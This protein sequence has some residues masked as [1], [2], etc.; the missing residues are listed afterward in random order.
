MAASTR[1][2]V[3]AT[4]SH[5]QWGTWYCRP[6]TLCRRE[7]RLGVQR[8]RGRWL[9]GFL[10]AA[11]VLAVVAIP[12]AADTSL[13]A[14][15]KAVVSQTNGDG[16]NVRDAVG[17]GGQ[18]I[19]ALPEGSEVD[20][21]G[22]P[23]QASDG[24]TWYQVSAYGVRGWVISDYL[25]AGGGHA[26]YQGVLTVVG[27]NGNGL[28]LRDG[29]SSD[30]ATLTVLPEGTQVTVVGADVTD[31]A[32]NTWANISFNGTTGYSS[33]AYLSTGGAPATPA[34]QSAPAP[35]SGVS[36][37]GNAEVGGTNGDGLNLRSDATYGSSIVAVAPDGS[38]VH[39]I[40]GSKTDGDGN[41]WWGVSYRGMT[42]WM[43]AAYLTP[44]DKQPDAGAAPQSAQMRTVSAASS[45]GDQIVAEAMKYVGYP[46][47][48]GGTTPAGFD[49][50]G[51]VYYVVNQV[52]GGGFPRS[53][54]GQVSSGSYVDQSNLQ[55]GDIV[56]QQ[57]TYQWGLSHD[58]IYIGNGQFINAANESTGV[59]ISNLND[60]YW[61]PRYY[62]ARRVG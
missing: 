46:Y 5:V 27:T 34:A 52:T 9:R 41:V 8:G 39:V 19:F 49:C 54:D 29:A 17:Y 16:V 4:V 45:I 15:Q 10:I 36:L 18:V 28:R 35:A 14:G 56:F 22:G 33:K 42:G 1:R 50:S 40:D 31:G 55:P 53:M 12:A 62:T 6:Y 26:S 13:T 58:G 23:A 59:T 7:G 38:V 11:M 2:R 51:F 60:S 61:R 57:N 25:S 43:S 3:Q 21:T 48:W 37:G 44:T 47:V 24:S 30:S 20:V 32:G